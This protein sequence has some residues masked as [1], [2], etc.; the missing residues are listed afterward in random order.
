MKGASPGGNWEGKLREYLRTMPP[1]CTG[2]PRPEMDRQEGG[3]RVRSLAPQLPSLLIICA[4]FPHP[5]GLTGL[6]TQPE[7]GWLGW[8]RTPH[9]GSKQIQSTLKDLGVKILHISPQSILKLCYSPVTSSALETFLMPPPPH[10]RL[11]AGVQTP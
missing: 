10:H 4:R 8:P 11:E 7:H 6:H 3:Q 2:W 9:A 1:T 5:D